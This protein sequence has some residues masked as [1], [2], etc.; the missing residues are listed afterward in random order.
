L[1]I[2]IGLVTGIGTGTGIGDSGYG[3]QDERFRM[4]D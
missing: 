2:G 4:R 3:I 1:R